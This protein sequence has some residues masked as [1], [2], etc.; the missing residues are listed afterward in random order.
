MK[1]AHYAR[2][3]LRRGANAT[4]PY[5]PEPLLLEGLETLNLL[6]GPNNSGKSMLLRDIFRAEAPSFSIQEAPEREVLTQVTKAVDEI[7]SVWPQEH[8]QY[9][10]LPRSKLERLVAQSKTPARLCQPH[11]QKTREL[12]QQLAALNSPCHIGIR[13]RG[14]QIGQIP[15]HDALVG[16]ARKHLATLQQASGIFEYAASQKRYYIPLLR[17]LRALEESGGDVYRART[18]AD[19]FQRME[20]QAAVSVLTP[21]AQVFTGLDLYDTLK[22]KLLGRP[23]ERERV[24][25]FEQF[26]GRHFFKGKPWALIPL[27]GQRV[28]EVHFG[29]NDQRPIHL[30]GDGLQN[31]I[32]CL[33]HVFTEADGC[34]FCIEEP[35]ISMH[36]G[37]QR[38]LIE[39]FLEKEQHQYFV[40]THSNH[41]L[42]M[43]LDFSRVAVYAC[44]KHGIEDQA[45]FRVTAVSSP[46]RSL[47]AALGVRN[48]SVFL[49]NATIWVEGITDRLY[50]RAYLRRFLEEESKKTGESPPQE[51][52]HYSFMEYQGSTIA[53]W[54]F[55]EGSSEERIGAEF[56]CA[57]VFLVADGDV[58]EKPDRDERLR[59][60]LGE[61]YLP[62]VCKEIE[63]TLPEEVVREVLG[64]EFRKHGA[65][66][67]TIRRAE[68]S[69]PRTPLGTYLDRL[70][71]NGA[72]IY[73]A[74]SGTLLEHKKRILC[75]EAVRA[76][77]PGGI[78]WELPEDVREICR[79]ICAFVKAKNA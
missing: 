44:S 14:D 75:R 68:Y 59:R 23:A 15:N 30:L 64:E 17:G 73:A 56:L 29:G 54:G 8:Q 1:T 53:H 50:L 24:R 7:N 41:M 26:L 36:P 57:T 5:D 58:L 78:R 4:L 35:D 63:N 46:D 32:I 27:E 33:F 74:K 37:Y 39:A 71:P 79:K 13:G 18:M 70:L 60:E 66:A 31:L 22:Q 6:V 65:N 72:T 76:M 40:T 51:D 10:Q 42:D 52:I 11:W 28:V 38:A 77:S 25:D 12:L 16:T 67:A 9:A 3:E 49:S 19:Y 62:L 47:L 20:G 69:L 48:S 45:R 43:T 34:V 21:R 61:R 2:L 55:E